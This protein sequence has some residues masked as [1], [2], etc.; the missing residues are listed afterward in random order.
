MALLNDRVPGS[1]RT[2]RPPALQAAR[3]AAATAPLLR[4]SIL[5]LAARPVP[6]LGPQRTEWQ[7]RE[8]GRQG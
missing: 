1:P 6:P 5:P 8:P 3:I 7:D 4:A 2:G